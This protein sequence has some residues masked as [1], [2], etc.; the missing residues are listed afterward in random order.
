MLDERSILLRTFLS[1]YLS[2]RSMSADA[3]DKFLFDMIY[4]TSY[5]DELA[6]VS[7]EIKRADRTGKSVLICSDTF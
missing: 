3:L 2:I 7:R 6:F 1:V 4:Q 5:H